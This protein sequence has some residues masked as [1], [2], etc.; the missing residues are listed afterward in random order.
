MKE[1]IGRKEFRKIEMNKNISVTT[2]LLGVIQILE[3][4]AKIVSYFAGP[5]QYPTV[6][7]L[8]I[9]QWYDLK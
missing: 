8:A 3:L 4:I 6:S 1:N 5:V 2:G 7:H 9:K